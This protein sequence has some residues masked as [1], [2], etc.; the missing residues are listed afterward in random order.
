MQRNPVP[1][2]LL[3]RAAHQAKRSAWQL[4]HAVFGVGEQ[5]WT[6]DAPVSY[7]LF[8]LRGVVSLQVSGDRGKRAN[9]ALLGREGCAEVHLLL[10]AEH[11]HMIATG[12]T[13]GEA[14]LM[15][16]ELFATFLRDPRFR[17]AVNRYI[18]LFVVMLQQVSFCNRI[19]AIEKTIIGRLLLIQDRT[20]SNSFQLTQAFFAD[21]LGVR[22]ATISRVAGRLQAQG[23]IRYDG[24]GRLTILDRRQMERQACSCYRTIKTES[25]NLIAAL[26]GF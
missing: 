8:P 2:N 11:S 15:P 4:K 19:H 12:F 10:G 20:Q 24:R 9:I 18:R 21:L 5:L 17:D 1:E 6:I 13:A 25:E 26:G 14:L 23:T 7:A 16:S 22:K 3:L